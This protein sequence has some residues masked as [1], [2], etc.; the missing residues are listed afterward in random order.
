YV[1]ELIVRLSARQ[2]P[3]PGLHGLYRRTVQRLADEPPIAWTLRRFERDFFASIGYAME[4]EHAADSGEFLDADTEYLYILVQG[5][6]P[7]AS[8][9]ALTV[10][11]G[12]LL[13]LGA[14]RM[15]GA[16]AMR[17]V[18]RLSRGLLLHHLG[19]VPLRSWQVLSGAAR[20]NNSLG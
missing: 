7:T 14:D 5:P 20:S 8:A 9:I 18:R 1:N 15:P 16:D 3:H 11:G 19:G 13:G 17:R 6:I 12:D 2:D 10:R 4:L